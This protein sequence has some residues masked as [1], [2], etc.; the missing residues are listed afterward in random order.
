MAF[1]QVLGDQWLGE[2]HNAFL[3]GVPD[4]QG[5]MPVG[6]QFTQRGNLADRFE[7]AGLDDGERLVQ[8]D[9]LTL[10]QQRDFDVRRARQPHLATGGEHVDGVVLVGGEQNAVAA[11]RLPQPVDFLT[12]R[13]QLL[14]GLF[15]GLHQLRVP[16]RK[17]VDARFQLMHIARGAGA[18][19]RT[20]G[21]LELLAQQRGL[22]A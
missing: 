6:Q 2:P 20:D 18:A 19:M 11:G 21:L 14:A 22:A 17:G 1:R 15:E 9:R 16:R 5:A 12:Q 3:V 13:Q 4:D 10:V 7:R 8:A